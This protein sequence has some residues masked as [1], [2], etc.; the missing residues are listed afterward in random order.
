MTA[1]KQRARAL[2]DKFALDQSVQFKAEAKRNAIVGLWA[3]AILGV[4][5]AEAYARSVVEEA[6]VDP[7]KAYEKLARDFDAAG[8]EGLGDELRERMTSELRA[9]SEALYQAR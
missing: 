1:M 4:D 5:D 3:A 8:V 7:S 6:V 2:E 9:V